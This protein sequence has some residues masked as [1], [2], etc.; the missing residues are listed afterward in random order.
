[1]LQEI[2]DQ[3]I[4]FIVSFTAN[5]L[6]SVS[7]GGA[8][9]VQ[10]PLLILMGLPFATALGTH[11]VAVVFL[12]IGA[13]SKKFK[14]KDT[15]ALNKT[16]SAIML[17]VGCPSV[18]LGTII[19]INVEDTIAEIVVGLLTIAMGTYTLF[20][21]KF[22]E[23]DS[24]YLTKKRLII[25][26]FC[27]FLVG[28]L[29]GSLSS[30]AGLFATLTLVAI[31]NLDLKSAI[32]HTM[33]FVATL[34]NAVGAVTVGALTAIYYQW[35]PILIIASFLGSFLGTALLYKL[36]TKAVRIVFSL[37]ALLSGVL[38]IWTAV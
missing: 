8:G 26:S 14:S 2:I 15:F 30:G 36:P 31:F 16:I 25:G 4:L 13:I 27:I 21:K 7:G 9:F 29:S 24:R 5:L 11:K 38:L 18:V 28:L 23:S 1:M 35:V 12:G 34:W 20:K 37:V 22:G 3:T 32:V 19:V 10:L 6:A 17:F 33:V